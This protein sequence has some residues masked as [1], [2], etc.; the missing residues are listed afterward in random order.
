MKKITALLAAAL[1]FA[2][3]AFAQQLGP[4]QLLG[5]DTASQRTPKPVTIDS[6]FDQALGA[7]ANRVVCNLA[8]VWQ[9][10]A[11]PILGSVGTMGIISFLGS[12]SGTVIVTP[13]AT[14]G[15]PTLTFPNA[16]GTFAV[17]GTA[18]LVLSATT[19]NLSI[20]TNG[21]T[22]TLL[23]QGA[24]LSVI[25]RSANTIGN[26]A[27]I[28]AGADFNILRRSGTAI[29]FGA[30]D[31]SQAGAVGTSVLGL[32]NGGS[33]KALTASNGGIVYTD[34]DSMEVLA[35]PG[36][37]GRL[38]QAQ[39]AAAPIWTTS[40]YPSA[41]SAGTILNAQSANT[42]IATATP[43]IGAN[44]GTGGTMTIN[45]STS[46]SVV[47]G[48]QAAAGSYNFN[49]PTGAGSAGQ[50]LLSGGGVGAAQTYGTLGLGA[51]GTAATSA[52]AARVSLVIDQLT[53]QGDANTSIAATTRTIATSATFTAARTWTLPAAN[54][55]NAGQSVVVLDQ[56]GG[57]NGANT[58]TI[59]RAGADT[60]NGGSAITLTSQ[61]AGAIVVSDGSSK[62]TA[63]TSGGG[64]SG[65]VTGVTPGAGLV[66][67]LT[68][69]CSQTAIT[70]SGTLSAAE[71]VNAQTGT[72][73]AILDSDRGKVVTGTNAAA[74]AY[75]IAQAGAASAFVAGWYTDVRN[76]STNPAGIITVTPTTSTI[77]G[78]SSITI[79]PGKSLRII[80]D[81]TNYQVAAN[82][83][84]GGSAPTQLAAGASGTYNTPNRTGRLRITMVGGGGGGGGGGASSSGGSGGGATC[85]NTTG[86]ACTTPVY[87]AGGGGVGGNGTVGTGGT[88]TGSGT[89]NIF[90][91]A[92]ANGGM[93]GSQSVSGVNF[94][95][96]GTGGG[97]F[98]G[99]GGPG[100]FNSNG[101]A[102]LVAGAG[103][104]GGSA[105]TA[106]NANSGGGGGAGAL[107]VAEIINPAAT[108]TYAVG[109]AGS[110]ATSGGNGG[111]GGAGLGGLITV[112]AFPQ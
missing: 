78:A 14:A 96:G 94:G 45:G 16:S 5:N 81:G 12:T 21:I 20:N 30:V 31:L 92:G 110:G 75:T 9:A 84:L 37:S 83:S 28:V 42:I 3:P 4:G 74:Q 24:A 77:D 106:S 8:G 58:L 104:G 29:G 100:G 67:S 51:G 22:D 19:G 47:I 59:Q 33:A 44:G 107:C 95:A 85:W 69:A 112:E 109:A 54:A 111:N 87:S 43:Q 91:I 34:A 53:T 13:Q 65:T 70:V 76:N 64:G 1:L 17:S 40:S 11:Q 72:S 79:G 105:F 62:W 56:F 68:A 7:T 48:V 99:S 26:V 86:A 32:S 18:P 97:S 61:F 6:I 10:C 52:A 80:S 98:F 35:N 36:A 41:S 38:V 46:G 39:N 63:L 71:C 25:G 93:Q 108:Y 90:G 103:G 23:R 88:I 55:V 60:I 27:D 2:A 73:Y 102:A 49:L 101:S 50:P 89:C 82:T 57:I 15:T 66:S